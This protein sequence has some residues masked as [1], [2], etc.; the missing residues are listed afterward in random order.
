MVKQRQNKNKQE[1]IAELE[2]QDEAIKALQGQFVPPTAGAA[3]DPA[4]ASPFDQLAV[5]LSAVLSANQKQQQE[6]LLDAIR[7]LPQPQ[8][9]VNAPAHGGGGGGGGAVGAASFKYKHMQDVKPLDIDNMSSGEFKSWKQTWKDYYDVHQLESCTEAIRMA[10]FRLMCTETT[11]DKILQIDMTGH[12]DDVTYLIGEIEKLMDAGVNVVIE[13]KKFSQRVQKTN[14][15]VGKFVLALRHLARDC[16]FGDTLEQAIKQ[17]VCLHVKSTY[18]RN[19]IQELGTAGFNQPLEEFVKQAAAFEANE[20]DQDKMAAGDYSEGASAR[21]LSSYKSQKNQKGL[22]DIGVGQGPTSKTRKDGPKCYNCGRALH[23]DKGDCPAKGKECHGCGKSGHFK[24]Q[25]RRQKGGQQTKKH[26]N[27]KRLE[28]QDDASVT[29]GDD[30][31]ARYTLT[32]RAA[33]AMQVSRHICR[34]PVEFMAGTVTTELQCIPDTGSEVDCLPL[35]AVQKLRLH[36]KMQKSDVLLKTADDSCTTA[37]GMVRVDAQFGNKQLKNREFLVFKECAPLL[38]VDTCV[39]F[40]LVPDNFP[41]CLSFL[42]VSEVMEVDM[43]ERERQKVIAKEETKQVIGEID[44]VVE[45][46]EGPQQQARQPFPAKLSK[47]RREARDRAKQERRIQKEKARDLEAGVRALR[48]EEEGKLKQIKNSLIAEF[49]D[50][51]S[52]HVKPMKGEPF[53]IVLKPGVEPVHVKVPRHV[54]IPLRDKLKEELDALVRDGVITKITSP[55]EWCSPI[56]C[57]PRKMSTRVRLCVDF[58]ELN[59][60]INREFYYSPAPQVSVCDIP[61]GGEIFH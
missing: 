19:K 35:E 3:G 1:L 47:E 51:F 33:A 13:R 61:R 53:R 20:Q 5:V 9:T 44:E 38:S 40:G 4:T 18:V 17:Q 24:T 39:K 31:D 42:D 14:E 49:P 26:R 48:D 23:K 54:S 8:V 15:S 41:N 32:V 6:G 21:K 37:I 27:A 11:R 7:N 59:R 22:R 45:V 34:V 36:D 25:C 2:Q 10:A 46:L 57:V 16:N 50:V 60:A 58:R 29:S 30:S 55:T 12:D 52:E 56:V 28:E 43:T